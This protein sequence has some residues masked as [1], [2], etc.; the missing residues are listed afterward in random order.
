MHPGEAPPACLSPSRPCPAH[1][2]L[3]RLCGSARGDDLLEARS[4]GKAS[5]KY[6]ER[7]ID[8]RE[9][10]YLQWCW[11]V[12]GIH[13]GL[14][15]TRKSGDDYPARVY[16]AHKTGLLPW[17]VESVNCVWSSSQPTVAQR[18]HLTRPPAGAGQR[19]SDPGRLLD[20]DR[21][22]LPVDSLSHPAD[23][24]RGPDGAVPAAPPY[25]VYFAGFRFVAVVRCRQAPASGRRAIACREGFSF[26]T[27][28]MRAIFI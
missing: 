7:E 2:L 23:F 18:R 5:A 24:H 16:V 1:H 4:R 20:P 21:R 8:L 13:E 9:T 11:Q 22:G 12:S 10:P 3:G 19:R 28:E 15:E 25:P 6:L 26:Q 17:Q 14:D 27:K